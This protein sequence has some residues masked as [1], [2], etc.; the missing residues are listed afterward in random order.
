[1]A[2]P[3]SVSFQASSALLFLLYHSLCFFLLLNGDGCCAFWH[4]PLVPTLGRQQISDF[5]TLTPPPPVVCRASSRTARATQRNP[6]S[7]GEMGVVTGIGLLESL[8]SHTQGS[9]FCSYYLRRKKVERWRVLLWWLVERY[10]GS[11]SHNLTLIWEASGSAHW[12]VLPPVETRMPSMWV[13]LTEWPGCR[14]KRTSLVLFSFPGISLV[15]AFIFPCI[16]EIKKFACLLWPFTL[17]SSNS[18]FYKA[19]ID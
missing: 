5:K 7:G 9:S 18:D 16:R 8:A 1:M 2:K 4:M 10:L 17:K 14:W 6:I 13:P 3:L 11:H 19:R 15:C 12:R